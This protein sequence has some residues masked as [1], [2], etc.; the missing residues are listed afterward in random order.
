MRLPNIG[1]LFFDFGRVP[2][3]AEYWDFAGLFGNVQAKFGQTVKDRDENQPPIIDSER[4]PMKQFRI[5]V[6]HGDGGPLA[7]PPLAAILT[8]YEV[9]P[10]GG[11]TMWSSM[12]A[13][14]D[15]LRRTCKRC[16]M[17]CRS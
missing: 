2:T 5:N 12:Y 15:A 16:S 4:M 11:E 9:P 8:A 13:A 10:A 3:S 6:W 17:A 7:V 14:Y 1:V